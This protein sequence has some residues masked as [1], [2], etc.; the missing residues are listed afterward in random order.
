MD[1]GRRRLE[2]LTE[3]EPEEAAR[4]LRALQRDGALSA[5][6]L[7][8]LACLGHAGAALL[9][10]ELPPEEPRAWLDLL[11]ARWGRGL[12]V[13]LGLALAPVICQGEHL[14]G[15]S[16]LRELCLCQRLALARDEAE[17]ARAATD[18]LI[19]GE[20]ALLGGAAG[21][22]ALAATSPFV[23]AATGRGSAQQL[24]AYALGF[25]V[26]P[27]VP[28]LVP[29]QGDAT[30]ELLLRSMAQSLELAGPPARRA[31]S[32]RLVAWV[33]RR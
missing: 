18:W 10:E 8:L 25:N 2:R 26:A 5:D 16:P 22:A 31:A 1:E 27:G 13:R 7:A 33:L 32:E 9:T 28:T 6:D 11:C 3:A 12:A 21:A 29:G 17:A 4:L 23:L 14:D 15:R 30:R 20:R 24:L 19:A